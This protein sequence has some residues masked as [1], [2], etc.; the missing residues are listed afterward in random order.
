MPRYAQPSG[1]SNIP[2]LN[3]RS[4]LSK[5]MLKIRLAFLSVAV[6]IALLF[7]AISS[8]SSAEFDLL[9][10]NGQIYD[11]SGKPPFNG[12]VA[13]SNG[14]IAEIGQITDAHGKSEVDARGL[15]VAP[16]FINMLSWA[17]ESLI[18]DGRSQSDIRQGVTLEIFG[19]VPSLGPLID[20]MKKEMI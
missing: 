9:I 20:A 16:G 13:V 2:C 1:S 14:R 17:T 8:S 18:Q 3:S 5:T 4:L 10:R 6:L 15:A 11:G 7:L 12:D 19:D